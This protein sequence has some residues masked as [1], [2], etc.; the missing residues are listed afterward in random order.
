MSY[1]E[2]LKRISAGAYL[3]H[4]DWHEN[5]IQLNS[6][7]KMKCHSCHKIVMEKEGRYQAVGD[8]EHCQFVCDSCYYEQLEAWD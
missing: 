5:P 6:K 1:K 8:Y 4:G 3:G 7:R 2:A